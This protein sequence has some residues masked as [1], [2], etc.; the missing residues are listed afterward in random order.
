MTSERRVRANARGVGL[1]VT[2]PYGDDRYCLWEGW[3]GVLLSPSEGIS[4]TEIE[5]EVARHDGVPRLAEVRRVRGGK[6]R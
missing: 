4:L 5:R 2:G 3:T 1:E 6:A